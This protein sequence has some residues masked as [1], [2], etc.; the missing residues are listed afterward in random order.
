M[1]ESQ[2]SYSVAHEVGR[3]DAPYIKR[4]LARYLPY[5]KG[6]GLVVDLGCGRGEFLELLAENG[7]PHLGVEANRQLVE[8]GRKKGL[9]LMPGDALS[10]VHKCRPRSVGGFFLSHIIEHLQ[11]REAMRTFQSISRALKPGGVLVVVT[12]NCRS[13][14]V[15]SYS[16]WRDLTHVR[17]YPAD[18]LELMGRENGLELVA[19]GETDLDTGENPFQR[20]L[21]SVARVVYR[22]LRRLLVGDFFR[23][24][25]LYVV[26]EKQ[27]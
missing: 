26:F 12:P 4:H 16:F 7:V 25:D 23:P 9:N 8:N 20:I 10:Y 15:I 11:P 24:F 3:L 17:P 14:S 6:K 21:R 1:A 27:G 19:K 13:L 2:K 22:G 18:L 5:F